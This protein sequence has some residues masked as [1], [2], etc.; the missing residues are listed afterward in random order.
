MKRRHLAGWLALLCMVAATGCGSDGGETVRTADTATRAS[1][2]ST[3]AEQAIG[4]RPTKKKKKKKKRKS[5][6]LA[7]QLVLHPGAGGRGP[8]CISDLSD[9]PPQ[10][11]T[12]PAVWLSG[13]SGPKSV[14]LALHTALCLHGFS[15]DQPVTVTV[16]AGTHRYQTTVVPA[17]GKIPVSG[18]ES[19]ETL[20]NGRQLRVFDV[21]EGVLE[22]DEWGFVPPSPA[23]DD[24]VTAGAI[25]TSAVQAG[26]STSYRQQATVSGTPTPGQGW[27]PGTKH[28]LVIFNFQQDQQVPVGLYHRTSPAKPFVLMRQIGAVTMPHSRIAVFTLPQTV[29]ETGVRYCVSVPLETLHDCPAP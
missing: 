28:Q 21:G 9:L 10:F 11:A 13:M 7:G 26:T 29:T 6:V 22:S 18:F 15:K 25:T 14:P 8:D 19:P 20:F 24:I 17:P 3:A 12:S 27:I 4:A 2:A 23:R 5:L 16:T 1:S